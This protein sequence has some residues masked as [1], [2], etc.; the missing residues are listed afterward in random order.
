ML[1]RFYHFNGRVGVRFCSYT[2]FCRN[3]NRKS[4]LPVLVLFECP[5]SAENEPLEHY[6][7]RQ[8]KPD[9]NIKFHE[10]IFH[11]RRIVVLIIPAAKDVPT[12]FDKVRFYRIGSSKVN[13]MDYPEREAQLFM[14]LRGE[15]PTIE[16][17]A[18]DYQDLTF[19]KTDAEKILEFC[20]TPRGILEIAAFLGY[21]DKRSVRKRLNP[22]LEQG[23]LAMNV[24][25]KPNSR[26][27]KYITIK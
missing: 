17:A 12:S 5:F 1:T 25:E 4:G 13:L 10:V 19:N 8:I 7:A 22:L 3:C 18:S 6:L 16:K 27:Q 24:P 11:G 15:I 26:L 23:R 20:M 21:K 9:I 14:A 2:L